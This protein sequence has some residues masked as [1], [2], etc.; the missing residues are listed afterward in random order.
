[1]RSA[2]RSFTEPPG[3][4]YS[5]LASTGRRQALGHLAAAS[6][7]G[8]CRPGRSSSRRTAWR[9]R[10]RSLHSDHEPDP[11]PA[12][13]ASGPR[14]AVSRASRARRIAVAAAYGGGGVGLLDGRRAGPVPAEV[15][16]AR[17]AI[18]EARTDA[19]SADGLYGKEH[20]GEPI[21]FAMLGDSSAAGFGVRA[22]HADPGRACSRPGSPTC[23]GRPVQL[24]NAR[25]G[26]A[27]AAATSTRRST[28]WP[29]GR[30]RRRGDHDRRQRRH[31]PRA[32]RPPPCAASTRPC[33][34][35]ARRAPR[36]W[37]APAPTSARSSRSPSRCAGSPGAGA[38]SWPPRRPSWWSR[39]AGARSPSATCSGRSS[40]RTRGDV[41]PRPLP[42]V[43]RGLR[44]APPTAVLPSVCAALDVW[45]RPTWRRPDAQPAPRPC[46]RSPRP[47]REAAERARHRGRGDPGRRTGERGP[48]GALGPAAPPPQAVGVRRG[49]DRRR[50]GLRRLDL[51]DRL[52]FNGGHLSQPDRGAS[53]PR[54]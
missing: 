45:S 49:G 14:P 24:T 31:P 9:Q 41:R 52:R 25:R 36:W 53:C 2:M 46:S 15:A 20:A 18:G 26:R 48:R 21:R 37:S 4:K 38:A 17:R 34:G 28:A 3:L 35:C 8:C 32:G 30:A 47:P 29:D 5:T 43:R 27:P 16:L 11:R 6:P 40:P 42:P 51:G 50:G 44:R 1:M 13:A 12:R 10:K 19:P 7:A 54:P 23:A 33:A 39:R 22:A